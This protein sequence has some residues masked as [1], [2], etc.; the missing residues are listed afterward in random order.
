MLC[1]FSIIP[2]SCHPSGLL[3]HIALVLPFAVILTAE[4]ILLIGKL[5]ILSKEGLITDSEKSPAILKLFVLVLLFGFGWTF[6]LVE[7]E[8]DGVVQVVFKSLFLLFGSMLGIYALMIYG[9][10]C[11][12][13]RS[14]W[15]SWLSCQQEE[16]D[17]ADLDQKIKNLNN[18]TNQMNGKH[19]P[20]LE[21]KEMHYGPEADFRSPTISPANELG[22]E[23]EV[24]DTFNET[25]EKTVELGDSNSQSSLSSHSSMGYPVPKSPNSSDK[26][27]G[28]EQTDQTQ[29]DTVSIDQPDSD[30]ET[31]L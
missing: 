8:T 20:I 1:I 27:I 11:K 21:F 31:A 18:G 25:Q 6:G 3:F 7:M 5:V 12:A 16:Y 28:M 23:N 29:Y 24:E 10:L 17:L 9:I 19:K 2:F 15:R 26:C 14:T 13:V 30:E 4:L 22:P